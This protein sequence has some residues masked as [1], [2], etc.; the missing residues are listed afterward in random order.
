MDKFIK[1]ES[2]HILYNGSDA[3]LEIGYR[4]LFFSLMLLLN[5]SMLTMFLKALEKNS[6]LTVS[7]ISTA[8]NIICSVC[9]LSELIN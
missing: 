5:G 7:V 1:K 8:F 3:N 6:S 4:V 9:Y 2:M